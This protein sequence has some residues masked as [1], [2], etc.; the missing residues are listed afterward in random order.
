[1]AVGVVK[2]GSG[3]KASPCSGRS[4]VGAPEPASELLFDAVVGGELGQGFLAH[5][6]ALVETDPL[7]QPELEGIEIVI[8]LGRRLGPALLQPPTLQLRC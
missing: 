7:R 4:L 2:L 6:A 5:V 3:L 8:D 1:M